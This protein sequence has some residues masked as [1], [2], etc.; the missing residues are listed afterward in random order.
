LEKYKFLLQTATERFQYK[1]LFLCSL[2]GIKSVVVSSRR[3]C[4]GEIRLFV[5]V[6]T[7]ITCSKR[8]T[9]KKS[10]L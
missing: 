4:L 2:I 8:S 7:F 3:L 9:R 10:R 1:Q 6:Q 5:A